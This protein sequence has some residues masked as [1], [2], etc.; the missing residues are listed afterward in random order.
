MDVLCRKDEV[1][2]GSTQ[3]M[4]TE[5]LEPAPFEIGLMKF[6]RNSVTPFNGSSASMFSLCYLKQ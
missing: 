1:D 4:S 2:R 5:P 6:T 3:I